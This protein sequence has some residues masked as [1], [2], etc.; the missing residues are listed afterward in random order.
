MKFGERLKK[1]RNDANETQ[2]SIANRLHVS[3]QTISNWENE[4]SYP[5]IEMLIKLSNYY[6][7]SLDQ[8]LKED[9]VM[10]EK[11]IEDAKK[12]RR[13]RNI[14]YIGTS[15]ILIFTIINLIWLSG[16]WSKEK[17]LTRYWETTTMVHDYPDGING[18]KETS[19]YEKQEGNVHL[20]ISK[21]SYQS[22]FRNDYLKFKKKPII[23][24]AHITK[25]EETEEIIN[26]IYVNEETFLVY[27]PF[28]NFME[29]PLVQLDSNMKVLEKGGPLPIDVPVTSFASPE[30]ITEANKFLEKN[31][32][33]LTEI[34]QV[35][36][37][38]Y[39]KMNKL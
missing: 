20:V 35:A 10:E 17:Y 32:N 21:E 18:P 37:N 11:V 9:V 19:I 27:V 39:K 22:K 36:D 38:E 28:K 3:R 2:E 24:A 8:L 13:Y 33:Q 7:I 23:M 29:Q 16:I 1:L 25:N 31:K 26:T 5:D 6:N 34:K 4:R 15:L 12:K 30:I 14:I